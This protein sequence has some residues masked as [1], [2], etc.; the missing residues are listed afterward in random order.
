M[1]TSNIP[2]NAYIVLPIQSRKMNFLVNQLCGS[3][4]DRIN[5]AV[6]ACPTFAY[7]KIP[8]SALMRETRTCLSSS[9]NSTKWNFG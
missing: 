1:D 7:I 8:L 3:F 5:Y 4:C 9:A 6:L 2:F